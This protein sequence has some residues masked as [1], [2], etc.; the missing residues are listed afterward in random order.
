MFADMKGKAVCPL[1]GDGVAA[2]KEYNVRGHYETKHHDRYKHLDMKPQGRRV[3]KKSGVTAG[4]V[5]KSQITKR[6]CCKG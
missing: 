3:E 1:C 6:G 5:H 4:N 2:M